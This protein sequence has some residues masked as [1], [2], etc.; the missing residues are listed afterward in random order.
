LF[1]IVGFVPFLLAQCSEGTAHPVCEPSLFLDMVF[2]SF[3]LDGIDSET[4]RA[5]VLSCVLYGWLNI[6][7]VDKSK[8]V[9]N[10][11][12]VGQ[13]MVG[14][15]TLRN[16]VMVVGPNLR[17]CGYCSCLVSLFPTDP[18]AHTIHSAKE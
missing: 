2:V 7:R 16:R 3:G 10:F 12:Y 8:S 18:T 6:E 17:T 4:E 9:R 11:R 15:L 1:W 14:G 13:Q 5:F